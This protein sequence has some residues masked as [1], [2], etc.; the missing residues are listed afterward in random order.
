M[1][2]VISVI[3]WFFARDAVGFIGAPGK[4]RS[5]KGE[6]KTKYLKADLQKADQKGGQ[7]NATNHVK[8]SKSSFSYL[9]VSGALHLSLLV[10]VQALPTV[11]KTSRQL[12]EATSENDTHRHHHTCHENVTECSDFVNDTVRH[13]H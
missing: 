12:Q 13:C 1:M 8:L 3:R 9:F 5:Q 4:Q 10:F 6:M 2:R 11:L 7:Q